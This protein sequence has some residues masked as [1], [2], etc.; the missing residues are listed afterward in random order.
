MHICIEI[1]EKLSNYEDFALKSEIFK[2][3]F[4]ISSN[5]VI[6]TRACNAEIDDN[7]LLI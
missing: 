3:L 7:Y 5:T 1:W 6:Q 2:A 4:I